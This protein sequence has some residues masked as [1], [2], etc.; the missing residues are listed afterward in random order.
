MW[1]HH[2]V[3]FKLY[4]SK[5][6]ENV[7][8]EVSYTSGIDLQHH[9]KIQKNEEN[10]THVFYRIKYIGYHIEFPHIR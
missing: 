1:Y 9:L 5:F 7:G 6:A 8:I 3:G 4:S 2:D 10:T